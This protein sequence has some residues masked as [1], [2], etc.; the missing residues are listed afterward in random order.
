[1][2]VWWILLHCVLC[3]LLRQSYC[4]ATWAV[5]R[6]CRVQCCCC[7]SVVMAFDVARCSLARCRPPDT[8]RTCRHRSPG[9][10]LIPLHCSQKPTASLMTRACQCLRRRW[11]VWLIDGLTSADP[12]ACR[13]EASLLLVRKLSTVSVS[14]FISVKRIICVLNFS[15]LS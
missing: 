3:E 9:S 2:L 8:R 5:C 6:H 11:D 4:S 10:T 14:H 12:V 1:M 13:A 15:L 7:L